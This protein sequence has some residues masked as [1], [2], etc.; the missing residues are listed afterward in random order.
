MYNLF[1]NIIKSLSIDFSLL[2]NMVT[3]LK[4]IKL[5]ELILRFMQHYFF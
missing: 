5:K 1:Y 4:V 2:Q 3:T